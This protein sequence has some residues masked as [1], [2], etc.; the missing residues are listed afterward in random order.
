MEPRVCK[1]V[2]LAFALA[3]RRRKPVSTNDPMM[4]PQPKKSVKTRMN[5]HEAGWRGDRPKG[6][7]PDS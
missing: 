5:K 1:H 3:M 2:Y 4:K 6:M 7:K